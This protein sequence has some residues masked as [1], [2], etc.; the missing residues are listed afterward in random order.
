MNNQNHFGD[1]PE[2]ITS[3]YSVI[4]KALIEHAEDGFFVHD[5]Q[6]RFLDVNQGACRSLGYSRAE[7]LKMSISD[8]E[9]GLELAA[10]QN[11]LARCRPGFPFRIQGRHQRKDGSI[12]PIEV[13][14]G[15]YPFREEKV[16]FSLVRDI[17]GKILAEEKLKQ[18]ERKFRRIVE[19]SPD[20]ILIQRDNA[21]EYL[22][23]AACR[24]F[25][26]RLAEQMSGY[27]ILDF[28]HHEYRSPF[29][30]LIMQ[31]Q[32]KEKPEQQPLEI[33][34]LSSQGHQIW[35][36][37]KGEHVEY[38]GQD[39]SLLFLRDITQRRESEKQLR[40]TQAQLQAA[41]DSMTDAVYISDTQGRFVLI[42]QA[43][44]SFYRFGS[45]EECTLSQ[46][47]LNGIL[48]KSFP[49]GTPVPHDQWS[50]PRALKGETASND[51]FIL[52]RVDTG[53]SW[54]G[55]YSFSPIQNDQGN[56]TGA[57]VV[58]RDI[59]EQKQAQRELQ[60]QERL[61]NLVVQNLPVGVMIAN[62]EGTIILSNKETGRIWAGAPKAGPGQYEEY[63]GWWSK[64]GQRIRS[65]EWALT[66]AIEHGEESHNEEIFIECFDG[67]CKTIL[68][69]AIPILDENHQITGAI[70]VNQD[71]TLSKKAE[72]AIK[73][74]EIATE[75]AKF[76]Q[77]FLANMSHEI[78]T[79]LTGVMGMISMLQQ[80]NPTDLQR[81]Y[82]NILKSSGETL[83]EIINQILDL[84][85]IEAG[86]ASLNYTIFEFTS[87]LN[88]ARKL[89]QGMRKN[90][91]SFSM[92]LDS[93]IPK[94]IEA[95]MS[96]MSQVVNNL[97]SNATKFTVAGEIKISA[98]LESDLPG[99]KE[100]RIRI[101]VQDTGIGIPR[102]MQKK[103]FTPFFQ[104][105]DGSTSPGSTGLGLAISRELAHLH[106]GQIGV[107]S[108]PQK[109]STFWFTFVAHKVSQKT[110]PQAAQ[111]PE[112]AKGKD[113]LNILL[114][115]DNRVNQ[116]VFEVILRHLGHQV[117][118][119]S[120]GKQA[121]E[122]FDP[123]GFDLILMDINMPVMD[124]IAATRALKD[125]YP[126]PP[127][128][129]GLSAN[130]VEGDREKYLALGMDE[131]LTKPLIEEE[132][133]EVI[134]KLFVQ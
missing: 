2:D 113:H 7:L 84:S 69:S 14:F 89:F 118:I 58:A 43:F 102:R 115:E 53:H 97:V 66:R 124:G 70:V 76:K 72:E 132:F 101:K 10:I 80:T 20:P 31:L 24:L 129:V 78:R 119:A 90:N 134:R 126:S 71:I 75:S 6:G 85:K 92:E 61:L 60:K 103:L 88:N 32:Q 81:E 30:T 96:R 13:Q 77:N 107:E 133:N 127:P 56:I 38:E 87:L 37:I 52:H 12:F 105:G 108:E 55:S 17:S 116:K 29:G 22:N 33:K 45:M 131:Y 79:P 109:G 74:A 9:Q 35:V 27:H 36:E 16:Y 122:K 44:A 114:V 65:N 8:I 130:A 39:S 121:L 91:V 51:E 104:V 120:D 99:G 23:P 21:I 25:G 11:A 1:Q 83:R 28:V 117:T 5:F 42:N 15:C 3:H 47:E 57:V 4:Y 128:I 59:T 18:S 93:R 123:E 73:K 67:T 40:E 62:K 86:K 110:T 54:D 63:K 112:A 95:D 46:Q 68:N 49:D 94:Y 41:I 34:M 82:I 100:I 111:Q 125:T 26:V 48:K 19:G 98:Q 50:V 106:G 64:T